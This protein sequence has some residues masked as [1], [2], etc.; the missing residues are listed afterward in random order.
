MLGHHGASHY[1]AFPGLMECTLNLSTKISHSSL[2]LLLF[3]HLI[4]ENRK[5]TKTIE[6]CTWLIDELMVLMYI[7]MSKELCPFQYTIDHKPGLWA[8]SWAVN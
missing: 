6:L 8:A 4:T 2:K 1:S 5:L 7:T 3:R